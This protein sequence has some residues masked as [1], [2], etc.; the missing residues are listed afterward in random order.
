MNFSEL[1]DMFFSYTGAST[2]DVDDTD[3]AF[4]FNE[5]QLDLSF[6]LGPV[7]TTTF[8][9]A[10]AGNPYDIPATAL[11][12]LDCS[13]DYEINAA[14]K[15][16]FA[17]S[18]DIELTYR[19]EPAEFT[20]ASDTE[21]SALHE[22]LHYLFV[23]FACARYWDKE[24]EGDSSESALGTKWMNYYLMGKKRAIARLTSLMGGNGLAD[25]W[26]II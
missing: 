2:S 25:K 24:S 21:E 18:G 22:S 14:G 5:A 12:I 9:N 23:I 16:V 6:D 10:V 4:W 3:L 8:K 7:S 13:C 20:A 19:H 26:T 15:I 17:S 11:Q 1:S